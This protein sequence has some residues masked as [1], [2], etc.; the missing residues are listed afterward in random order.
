M[1][2]GD[3][4]DGVHRPSG[5]TGPPRRDAVPPTVWSATPLFVNDTL[6]VGTPFYR[7]FALEPDTGAVKWTYDSQAVLEA[8]TQPDLKNR[9]VAYWAAADAA[10]GQ[11]CQKR[12]YLG[13]MDAKLHAVD[14]DTGQPC[15]DFGAG[16][17]L[18]FDSFN[19]ADARW[20][21]SL[22]QPPTVFE[23]HPLPRLG[24]QGLGGGGR[25]PGSVYRAR[26]PHRR[27]EVD[28]RHPAARAARQD[29]HRQHLGLHVGRSRAPAPLHPG[30]VAKPRLLPG[31]RPRGSD[32]M[33]TR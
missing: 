31:R 19:T 5:I 33:S 16:G 4:S 29:R 7:I 12:I 32:A 21:L 22:L 23:R 20:P 6:Y 1:H 2:T 8:L 11:P 24:R 17:V 30:V 18:D 14:A 27:G 28:L 25:S 10:A 15:A 13:T 3:V 26:R 9:G